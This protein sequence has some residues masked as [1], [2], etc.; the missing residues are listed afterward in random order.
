MLALPYVA[1]SPDE[2]A[3]AGVADELPHLLDHGTEVLRRL[4]GTAPRQ[5]TWLAGPDLGGSGLSLLAALGVRQAVVDPTHVERVTDGVLSPARPF[6]LGA[7]RASGRGKATTTTADA[8]AGP[9]ATAAATDVTALVTDAALEDRVAAGGPPA[10]IA[11]RVLAELA[12]LWFE[13]PGTRRAVVLPVGTTVDGSAV[14][15]ILAGLRAPAVFRPVTVDDAFQDA[16]PLLARDGKPLRRSLVPGDGLAIPSTLATEIREG[17]ALRDSVQMMVGPSSPVLAAVDDH[18]LRSMASRLSGSERRQ[19]L[20]AARDA[21]Q[22]LADAVQAPDQVTI[23][24]TA[25]DGTVPLT[26]RN[27]TGGSVA[28]EVHLS[29]PKLELPGGDTIPV[30][31]TGPTTRLD[32]PVRTRASGAFPIEV[33]V[34]SPDGRVLLASTKYSVRS[35]AVSGVGLVLSAGAGVFLVVWWARHWREAR[36][37]AKLVTTA[38]PSVAGARPHTEE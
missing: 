20:Q 31:L 1:S 4:L 34:T 26:I 25:R 19:E 10:L 38:H 13:Q 9:A 14:R 27:D 36:R 17:R 24:L 23:T 5:T 28:A 6:L 3:A 15:Q 33:E 16:A 2:L 8:A 18:L 35:T 12:A 22:G 29:G 11:S 30:T 37:S 32:I 7:P 21:V